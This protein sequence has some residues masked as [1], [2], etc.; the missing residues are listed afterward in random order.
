MPQSI[1]PLGST[2]PVLLVTGVPKVGGYRC[3]CKSTTVCLATTSRTVC[4][5]WDSERGSVLMVGHQCGV[6]A[7]RFN[8]CGGQWMRLKISGAIC[9]AQVR[10]LAAARGSTR[11]RL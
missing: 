3:V 5:S 6:L 8:T 10:A 11:G 1:R 2:L 4:A 7:G 9:D